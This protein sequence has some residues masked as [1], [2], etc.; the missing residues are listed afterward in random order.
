MLATKGLHVIEIDGDGNCL[1]RAI[2]HQVYLNEDHHEE[3]RARVVDHLLAHQ[4][5]FALFCETDFHAYI[6]ELRQL[7][8]WGDEL[9][10]RALEELI[11]RH[12]YIYSSDSPTPTVPIHCDEA[13]T[14][15]AAVTPLKLS[16]HG[17]NHYNSIYDEASPLPLAVRGSEGLLAKRVALFHGRK[18]TEVGQGAASPV[19]AQNHYPQQLEQQQ[20]FRYSGPIP[21]TPPMPHPYYVPMHRGGRHVQ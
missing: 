9:E 12:I 7:G 20:V 11:D 2:S 19:Q 16:Y 4:Q 10:I 14:A 13:S 15:A 1:F 3:L 6:Q 17:Q 8:T 5:R 18:Q 21:L